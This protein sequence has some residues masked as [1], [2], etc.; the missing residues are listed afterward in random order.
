[1][2][3]IPSLSIKSFGGTSKCSYH[4][5]YEFY[6][7]EFPQSSDL[8]SNS[9]IFPLLPFLFSP[10]LTSAGTAV[11]MIIPFHSFLSI[12]TDVWSSCLY[13]IVT[14]NTDIPQ[15]FSFLIFSYSFWGMFIPRFRMLQPILL[16]KIP[17]NFL[18]YIVMSSLIFFLSQFPTSTY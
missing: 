11:S 1:M 4:Y 6:P 2:G 16:T 14:L 10:T 9:G 15:N 3:G 17:M 5:A 7:I 8:S 12:T 18:C 13:R